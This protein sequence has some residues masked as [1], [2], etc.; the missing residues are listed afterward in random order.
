MPGENPI[1]PRSSVSSSSLPAPA[2]CVLA[3]GYTTRNATT[4]R[5]NVKTASHNR[6]RCDSRLDSRGFSATITATTIA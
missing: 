1:A 5:A 4:M 6:S 3:T 2:T